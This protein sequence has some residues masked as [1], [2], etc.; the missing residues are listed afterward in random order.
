MQDPGD[1]RTRHTLISTFIAERMFEYSFISSRPSHTV[2][3]PCRETEGTRPSVGYEELQHALAEPKRSN[4]ETETDDGQVGVVGGFTQPQLL[5]LV[6]SH[7]L[8]HAVEDVVV[9]LIVGLQSG[10]L[11]PLCCFCVTAPDEQTLGL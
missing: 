5:L 7:S 2:Q 6:C 8:Q 11:L 10:A 3:V 9:S 1:S 4:K